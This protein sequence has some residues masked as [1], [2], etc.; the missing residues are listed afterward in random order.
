[1][2]GIAAAVSEMKALMLD[3]RRSRP[4]SRGAG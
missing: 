2:A 3:A 4:A 1:V